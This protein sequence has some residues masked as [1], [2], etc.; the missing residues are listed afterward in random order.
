MWSFC[1]LPG[2]FQTAPRPELFAIV[3]RCALCLEGAALN[4]GTD[5][6]VT[7]LGVGSGRAHGLNADLWLALRALIQARRLQLTT[8]KIKSHILDKPQ[9]LRRCY[10]T[11]QVH[12][13]GNACADKLAGRWG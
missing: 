5:S 13:F 3:V 2:K 8:F 10:P 4:V 1:P 7:H 12:A 9:L 11:R 6:E